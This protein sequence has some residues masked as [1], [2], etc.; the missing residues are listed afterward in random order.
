MAAR[1]GEQFL[2]GLK[3]GRELWVGG[4]RIRS[5]VDHPALS[6]AAHAL[7]EVFDLQHRHAQDCLMADPETGESINVSHMIPRSRE[8][9]Q[10]RHRGLERVA[11]FSVGLMGRTP[12]YMNVTYAGFAGRSDEWAVNGNE[13]GAANLVRYQ[14]KLARE[15]ISLTHTI[16]HSTVDLAK[17]KYPVGFDPVQLHKVENT[18]TGILV[19]GSRV[20]ATLAPFADELAV[21]PGGPMPNAADV[22]ALSFCIPMD[23]PGLKF[24]CRDSVAV[25]TNRFEHPLSSRFDEQD[26]FVIFDDVEVPRERLFIDANLDVYNT[27]MKTSWWPNIMQQTMIRAQ[28][29]LE[30][31]WSLATRMAETI[32]SANQPPTQQML[33]EIAMYAEFARAA[34]YAAEQAADALG[35][36]MWS[37]DG[38]PLAALRAALP[39]WFPRVNEIIRLIGSHNLLTTPA[40]AALE[41]ETLRPLVEKYLRGVGVDAEQR[42]RLFRL[43]W[44]FAGT[45]LG[46]RNEQYERFYLGSVGRNLIA[47]QTVALA[48]RARANRLL[49]R[50]LLEEWD[51]TRQVA[52]QHLASAAS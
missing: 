3:D 31:A 38:R 18:S 35:N 19:R 7:A 34:V 41:D 47:A 48:D 32:N 14:K 33:G 2:R 50:F 43:A 27:V 15:D 13:A 24:I 22:H 16:V 23:T 45:A 26:A 21:Y 1:T 42:S 20:L 9:L 39:T 49:D 12:D 36:G 37:C 28:T 44:D 17:G 51:D 29:K 4:E 5:I 46:S 40:R 10:R 11:E 8:D 25:N 30:F 6:G 52:P